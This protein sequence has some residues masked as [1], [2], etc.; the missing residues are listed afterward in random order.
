MNSEKITIKKCDVPD[1]GGKIIDI[2]NDNE[3]VSVIV[4]RRGDEFRAFVNSCTHARWRLENDYGELLFDDDGNLICAG[5]CAIFSSQD[6][7]F[8]GG[9]GRGRPLKKYPLVTNEESVILL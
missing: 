5:H 8:L 4:I 7:S 2:E 9:P 1:G 3:L 6:G